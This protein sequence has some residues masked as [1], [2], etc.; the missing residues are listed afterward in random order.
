MDDIPE[1]QQR[2]DERA[3]LQDDLYAIKRQIDSGDYDAAT[4]G[5]RVLQRDPRLTHYPDLASEVLGNLGTL[6]LFNAQGEENSA[7][8]GPMIDEAI[9]LLNRARSMR[10]NAGFPTAIFDANL[11]LAH[12]QKFRLNGRPGELL[13]GKLILDGTRASTDPDLAEWIGAIRKCFDTPTRP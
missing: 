9:E 13:V 6:L 2:P 1:D 3:A 5:A 10:R 8:A 12:Y 7:E 4:I 11:A